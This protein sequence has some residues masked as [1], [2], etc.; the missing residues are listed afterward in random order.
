[1]W[2]RVS[3]QKPSLKI[4]KVGSFQSWNMQ[5]VLSQM[6]LLCIISVCQLEAYSCCVFFHSSAFDLVNIHLFHD[7]SNLVAWEKSPSV[8]SGTRSKALG[9]ILDRYPTTIISYFFIPLVCYYY[10]L[11]GSSCKQMFYWDMTVKKYIQVS[12]WLW[13][14]CLCLQ[15]LDVVRLNQNVPCLL[16]SFSIM[17]SN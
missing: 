6:H 5:G 10:E 15:R 3:F 4:H 16:D 12:T 14:D 17:C 8:Y 2:T 11:Q 9:Y 7:A 1:M 13:R